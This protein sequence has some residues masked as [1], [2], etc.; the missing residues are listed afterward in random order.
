VIYPLLVT[1]I[2]H[3]KTK[4]WMN[5]LL[6]ACLGMILAFWGVMLV[7][8]VQNKFWLQI[9]FFVFAI[10]MTIQTS[11]P[12]FERNPVLLKEWD[13]PLWERLNECSLIEFLFLQFHSLEDIAD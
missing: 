5:T 13:S 12:S 3:R 6:F 4:L 7:G 9:A 1:Y 2:L 8:A 10:W 11:I